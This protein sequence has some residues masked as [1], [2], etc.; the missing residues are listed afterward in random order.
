MVGGLS[1]CEF[2]RV[3]FAQTSIKCGPVS[4]GVPTLTSPPSGILMQLFSR[5][6]TRPLFVNHQSQSTNTI[7][8]SNHELL[9]NLSSD[10]SFLKYEILFSVLCIVSKIAFA[11]DNLF[12]KVF[13]LRNN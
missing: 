8:H 2:S 11:K 4:P 10:S 12:G 6:S 1:L 3:T 5:T 9:H 13:G 7:W